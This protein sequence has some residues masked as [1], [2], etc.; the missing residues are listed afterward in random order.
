VDGPCADERIAARRIIG[1]TR[2]RVIR[3][4][5]GTIHVWSARGASHGRSARRAG[6]RTA[7]IR[8]DQDGQ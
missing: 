2:L 3:L 8:L 1:K 6:G 7:R 4:D 5:A